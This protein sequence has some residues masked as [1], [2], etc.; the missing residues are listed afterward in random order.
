M[1]SS[2]GSNPPV[3]ELPEDYR[4]LVKIYLDT[5]TADL[6][7]VDRALA[8]ADFAAI[9]RIGHNL[10]GSSAAYG[11]HAAGELGVALERAAEAADATA[12]RDLASK[13]RSYL[14]SVEVRFA[15]PA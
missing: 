7:A 13:L 6:E 4:E 10:R 9:R 12:V 5:R 11:F 2:S 8:S 1:A 14:S 15:P 3:V